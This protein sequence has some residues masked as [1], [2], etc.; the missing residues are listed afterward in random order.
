MLSWTEA[1][2]KIN[3]DPAWNP[4]PGSEDW[5]RIV[6]IYGTTNARLAYDPTAIPHPEMPPQVVQPIPGRLHARPLEL[7][8]EPDQ[9]PSLAR[10]LIG[11]R[12]TP[13][14][15]NIINVSSR[16]NATTLG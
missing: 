12:P 4:R 15:Q 3:P 8:G 7:V 16:I 13:K 14:T 9:A 11:K 6:A 1:K 10:W 5:K 2:A